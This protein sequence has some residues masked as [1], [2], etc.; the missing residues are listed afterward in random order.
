MGASTVSDGTFTEPFDTVNHEILLRILYQSGIRGF[1]HDWISTYLMNRRQ[2]TTVNGEISSIL[3]NKTGV[4]QGSS[5]GPLLFII[6]INDIKNCLMD[7]EINIY[8]DDTSIFISDKH[9]EGAK[10]KAENALD[11]ISNYMRRKRLALNIMKTEFILLTP[12][13]KSKTNT[14]LE[15][16][17]DDNLITQ[18]QHTKFLGVTI[19]DRLKFDIHIQNLINKL[20]RYISLYYRLRELI[21]LDILL[22]LHEQLCLPIIRYCLIIYGGTNKT[23][24]ARLARMHKI[25]FKVIYRKEKTHVDID[26]YKRNNFLSLGSMYDYELLL[27]AYKIKFLKRELPTIF[28][29]YLTPQKNRQLRSKN[30]FQ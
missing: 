10:K 3:I 28:K 21:P 19:D 8:A 18:V 17:L 14:T 7:E 30:N 9:L 12:R 20:K 22:T 26:F 16:K 24:K 23:T 27:L 11:K 2:I 6:Y 15:L 13:R 25:L 4:P 29:N 5:L 1:M